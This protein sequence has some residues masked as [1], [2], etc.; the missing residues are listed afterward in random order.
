MKT[1][2]ALGLGLL[3]TVSACTPP[4]PQTQDDFKAVSGLLQTVPI[5]SGNN[6]F[7]LNEFF[8]VP[9][10]IDSVTL[11][12]C[13]LTYDSLSYRLQLQI[14]DDFPILAECHV[15]INKAAFTLLLKRPS[16]PNEQA[17]TIRSANYSGSE[18][19]IQLSDPTMHLII[20][21]ENF[22]LDHTLQ[23]LEGN[24]I[25]VRIPFV[26]AGFE[27][28]TLRVFGYNEHGISNDIMI[29]LVKG[30]VMKYAEQLDRMDKKA[31]MVYFMMIDRFYNG[32]FTNDQPV[33]D[34]EVDQRANY[35]GGDIA[36]ILQKVRDGYF[37]SLG[38]N[39]IWLSPVTQNTLHAFHEY[40][41]PHRKFTG[42][43]G[44]WPISL[45]QP[46][47]RFGT[48]ENLKQLS[49]EVHAKKMNILLDFV[50]NHVHE[51]APIILA[52]PEWK[53][54]L[55][56][57]DGSKNIRLWDEQRLTTWFDSFLPSLDYS[58]PEVVQTMTDSVMYWLSEYKLDGFRHD[59]TKHIPDT[60]WRSLTK[61]IHHYEKDSIKTIYQIGETYGDYELTGSYVGSNLLD[62]QFDFNLYWQARNCFVLDEEPMSTL[63]ESIAK[64]LHYYGSHHTMGNITGNHDM[65][66][67][68]SYAGGAL[69]FE[70]DAKEIA[71]KDTIGVG[72]S[73]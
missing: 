16:P 58:N 15:W 40:P 46:D 56:L 5:H 4:S 66:R 53:T 32:D 70:D 50:S 48:K 9:E 64:S 27:R 34:S 30:K 73:I 61:R 6:E 12:G 33:I 43:H 44:Y 2:I 35:Y 55:D 69:K 51:E 14:P 59:A 22:S 67:F 19:S 23:E 21:W 18:I 24:L 29:P 39:T 17:P 7:Y 36:G 38:V 37:D 25:K 20:L 10:Q 65:P 26:A 45:N 54:N 72:D 47:F 52:N 41:E 68:A 13:E 63:A 57:P 3:I 60:F 28:S 8:L 42:Y 49:N 11:S 71:W 62:A 31:I 1:W